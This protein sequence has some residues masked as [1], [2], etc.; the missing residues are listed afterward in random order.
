MENPNNICNI[1][2]NV[3]KDARMPAKLVKY[4]TYK[5]KSLNGFPLE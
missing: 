4:K 2:H 3:I 1:L 5:H